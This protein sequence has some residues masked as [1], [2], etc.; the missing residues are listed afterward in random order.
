MHKAIAMFFV[1]ILM[2]SCGNVESVPT[3]R[4]TDEPTHT[5]I[6][7]TITIP[8]IVLSSTPSVTPTVTPTAQTPPGLAGFKMAYVVD[9][10][11]Y[12]QNGTNAPIQLTSG[13]K[14][15]FPTFSDDGEKLVFLRGL[16]PRDLYSANLDGSGERLLISGRTL[17]SVAP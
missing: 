15:V 11:I 5:P 7:P 12:L 6:N 4:V 2:V 14:D 16:I 17:S 3:L 13:E 9:G 1:V 10:N 8:M